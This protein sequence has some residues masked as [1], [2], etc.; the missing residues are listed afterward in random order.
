MTSRPIYD[1]MSGVPSE[2]DRR[3]GTAYAT[4]KTVA[5]NLL[6]IKYVVENMQAIHDTAST[7]ATIATLTA[8]LQDLNARFVAYVAT[9]P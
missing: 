8:A 3:I 7:A 2:I 9:H 6:E 1:P 4:V 5:D